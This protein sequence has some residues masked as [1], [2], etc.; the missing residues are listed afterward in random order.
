MRIYGDGRTWRTLGQ[1]NRY[2]LCELLGHSGEEYER[3]EED[4]VIGQV[5]LNPAVTPLPGP[6]ALLRMGFLAEYDR[7]YKKRLGLDP[8]AAEQKEG[9]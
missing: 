2:V 6:E 1:H 4:Q 7:D 8:A 3:L 5:P 9:P